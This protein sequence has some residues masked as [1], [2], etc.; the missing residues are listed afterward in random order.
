MWRSVSDPAALVWTRPS[1]SLACAILLLAVSAARPAD[2]EPTRFIKPVDWTPARIC[3]T[4]ETTAR[5][6]N[7]PSAFFARLI[8]T[9][10]RFDTAAV[11]PKGA[12]GIAQFMPA[13]ARERGLEDPLDPAKALPAS[14]SFLSELKVKFGN[15]GLAAAAYNAGGSRVSRWLAGKSGLPFETQDYVAAI[16]G[17]LAETFRVPD[18]RYEDNPLSRKKGF[19]EACR[20]LPVVK[21]RF[22]GLVGP[23]TPWGVQV[24]GNFSQARAIQSWTRVRARLGIAVSEAQPALYRQPAPRGMKR[25]W[26]V[27]LG[28]QT[29]IGAIRLCDR[30]RRAGGSCIV[31]KN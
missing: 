13:T 12:L 6:Y 21:T 19:Q 8:W 16:T 23:R 17:H 15:L 25:K 1:K 28:T 24:A 31:R 10:S 22:R 3:E 7:L 30:I 26:T 4:I 18:A 5:R 27:R 11:S 9:E 20:E 29:R 14:A 2:A